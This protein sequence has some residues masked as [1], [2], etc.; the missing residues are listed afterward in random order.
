[1]SLSALHEDALVRIFRFLSDDSADGGRA[2]VTLADCSHY[3]RSLLSRTVCTT[4]SNSHDM[5]VL[6]ALVRVAG[7]NL[8]HLLVDLEVGDEHCEHICRAVRTSGARLETLKL[9][10]PGYHKPKWVKGEK[11][12]QAEL[13]ALLSDVRL[14][15]TKLYLS[16][17][18]EEVLRSVTEARL[19]HLQKLACDEVIVSIS[20]LVAVLS[21]LRAVSLHGMTIS[22]GTVT[23]IVEACQSLDSL[24]IS[25]CGV[26]EV[27][28]ELD[29]PCA[30]WSQVVRAAGD[31]LRSLDDTNPI[32]CVDHEEELEEGSQISGP[33]REHVKELLEHCPNLTYVKLALEGDSEAALELPALCLSLKHSV[34][35]LDLKWD[36]T[37]MTYGDLGGNEVQEAYHD[38]RM[39]C[40]TVVDAICQTAKLVSVRLENALFLR[41]QLLVILAHIGDNL[42]NFAF[43]VGH[44]Q[45]PRD[46]FLID[47]FEYMSAHNPNLRSLDVTFCLCDSCCDEADL[48]VKWRTDEAPCSVINAEG[49]KGDH[50]D[51]NSSSQPTAPKRHISKKENEETMTPREVTFLKACKELTQATKLSRRWVDACFKDV[52]QITPV[53]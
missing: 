35:S 21:R 25:S 9:S 10:G 53:H 13:R 45:G 26:T 24:Y 22:S 2:L 23:P 38:E 27:N 6:L 52:F 33:R 5:R 49:A 39:H 16:S 40:A 1:M 37:W 30:A 48:L 51:L 15:I 4:I 34:V 32:L 42:D 14:S 43:T 19:A 29:C 47:I 7:S 3:L 28:S 50:A 31:K 36:E 46:A 11:V 18:N 17:C 41:D 12:P 8:R 20:G 44:R